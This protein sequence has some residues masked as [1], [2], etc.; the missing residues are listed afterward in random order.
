VQRDQYLAAATLTD[1]GDTGPLMFVVRPGLE[2]MAA[3]DG[4]HGANPK[5][6]APV[7]VWRPA[8]EA[9]P[10]LPASASDGQRSP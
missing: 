1:T 4:I 3:S 6:D 7:W 10:R 9:M 5:G 8:A 2:G